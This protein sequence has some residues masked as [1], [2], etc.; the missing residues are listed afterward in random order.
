MLDALDDLAR[1]FGVHV[2]AAVSRPVSDPDAATALMRRLRTS[3]PSRLAGFASTT[4]DLLQRQDVGT[5]ALI[6]TGGDADTSA[7]VAVRPSGTEPKV[8][9][10]IEVAAPA[11]EDLAGVRERATALCDELA[12]LVQHW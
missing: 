5:D 6:F 8:K 11:A 2:G 4:A 7:R 3:P 10:Y 1:R 9:F 12:S